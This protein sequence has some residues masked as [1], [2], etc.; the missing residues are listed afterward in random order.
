MV[1]GGG[2]IENGIEDDEFQKTEFCIKHVYSVDLLAVGSGG[3]IV[4]QKSKSQL[5]TLRK[6]QVQCAQ[7]TEPCTWSIGDIKT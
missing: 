1:I 7:S 5:R 4:S 2:L 3:D 6:S